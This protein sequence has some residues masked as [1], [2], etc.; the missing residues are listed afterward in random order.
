MLILSADAAS[1]GKQAG[2]WEQGYNFVYHFSRNNAINI[3]SY[4]EVFQ[5]RQTVQ[6][7]SGIHLPYSTLRPLRL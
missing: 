1:D 2:A 6:A 4:M 3:C 7:A 5:A